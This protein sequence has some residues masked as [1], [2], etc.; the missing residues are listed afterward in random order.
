M[1]MVTLVVEFAIKPGM[2]E[3]HRAVSVRM[4]SAVEREEPG[5]TGYDW[6]LSDDGT[7]GVDIETFE[8][9]DALVHHMANTA[10]LVAELVANADVLRVEVLGGLTPRG[11]PPCAG[12]ATGYF[13]LMGG[14]GTGTRIRARRSASP[15]AMTPSV[16]LETPSAR[17]ASSPSASGIVL[18][19]RGPGCEEVIAHG[20]GGRRWV[21]RDD[22]LVDETV[23]VV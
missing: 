21:A 20:L 22:G 5:T 14:I 7:R 3:A 23:L 1:T 12:A 8:D 16:E 9:S 2:A 18:S 6:W 4:R 10:P 13:T 19:R 11:G 15:G 17:M